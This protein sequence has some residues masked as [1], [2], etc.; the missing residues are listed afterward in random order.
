MSMFELPKRSPRDR[1]RQWLKHLHHD[2]AA[3]EGAMDERRRQLLEDLSRA[4][5]EAP[6]DVPIKNIIERLNQHR[7]D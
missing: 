2:P 1:L 3:E 7:D 5:S 6:D 4:V